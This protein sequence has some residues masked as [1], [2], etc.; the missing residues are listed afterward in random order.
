[1]CISGVQH[2]DSPVSQR[3]N[4]VAVVV[5]YVCSV[6]LRHPD[7][8][9]NKFGINE[10]R[11]DRLQSKTIFVMPFWLY[12]VDSFS[13]VITAADVCIMLQHGLSVAAALSFKHTVAQDMHA[14]SIG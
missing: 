13:L 10:P 14:N 1:M 8:L 4:Q 7:Q 2:I 5:T 9:G 11:C 3:L 12:L 6:S